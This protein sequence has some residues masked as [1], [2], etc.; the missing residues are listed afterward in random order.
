MTSQAFALQSNVSVQCRQQHNT[1]SYKEAGKIGTVQ[2]L[3]RAF[4]YIYLAGSMNISKEH[5][6]IFWIKAGLGNY[7]S[8]LYSMDHFAIT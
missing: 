2:Q 5:A 1:C 3:C 6:I 4:F 8:L 7:S